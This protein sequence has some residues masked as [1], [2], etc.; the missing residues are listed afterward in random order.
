[1]KVPQPDKFSGTAKE[2]A[3]SRSWLS[4]ARDWLSLTVAD[5]SEDVKVMYFGTVLS[6]QA[7]SWFDA[8]KQR[9]EA[10]GQ[11]LTL[12]VLFDNFQAAFAESRSVIALQQELDQLRY[13]QGKCTSLISTETQ[14]D[15]LA[16]TIYPTV[17][18]KSDAD[19]MLGSSYGNVIKRGNYELWSMATDELPSGLSGLAAWKEAVQTAAAKLK[20]KAG[21]MSRGAQGRP[22]GQWRTGST[23]TEGGQR[24]AS[25]SN[26]NAREPGGGDGET[27]EEAS[28]D[29]ADG[30]AEGQATS[31]AEMH[32]RQPGR[33]RGAAQ[34]RGRGRGADRGRSSQ[35]GHQLTS[36]QRD[37]LKTAER[38]FACYEKG[39]IAFGCKQRR[40]RA[41]TE[42]ELNP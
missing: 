13:G 30:R 28:S 19:Y 39:H 26:V 10:A 21:G 15:A 22:Q 6:G 20:N 32:A 38:C 3:T 18:P 33:G 16:F 41:P 8:E 7:R 31:A 4:A 29:G 2:K 5:Q 27:D 11:Q 34:G 24:N 37:A 40:S 9:A 17:E 42:D 36:E 14:F 1:V 35:G 25:V 12:A 23:W